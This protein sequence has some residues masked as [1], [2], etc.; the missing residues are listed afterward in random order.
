MPRFELV[1]VQE[2][3]TKS[4]SGKS[5]KIAR[6]Y[7][8]YIEQLAGGQAGRLQVTEGETVAT[9]RRRLG[10]AA[11]FGGK[12]LVIKRVGNEVYFWVKEEAGSGRRGGRPRK[13]HVYY[14]IASGFT[15]G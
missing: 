3:M 13:G 7:L 12:D 8:G 1:P 10:A 4:A 5:A 11:K 15:V 9:I 6:E 14:D 2:A